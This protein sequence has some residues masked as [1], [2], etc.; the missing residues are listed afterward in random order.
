VVFTNKDLVIAVGVIF[1]CSVGKV[2]F[3][4]KGPIVELVILG[5]IVIEGVLIIFEE[6]L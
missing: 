1:N 6:L 4:V 5:I 2:L 3:T